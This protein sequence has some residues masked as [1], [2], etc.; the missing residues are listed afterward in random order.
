[1]PII[2]RRSNHQSGCREDQYFITVEVT[3]CRCKL[4]SIYLGSDYLKLMSVNEN[5]QIITS[6]RTMYEN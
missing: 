2:L 1:M 5:L 4:D 6:N 3:K